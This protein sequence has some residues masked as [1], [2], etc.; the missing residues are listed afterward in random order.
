MQ[1]VPG[2]EMTFEM[3]MAAA[4]GLIG[5]LFLLWIAALFRIRRLKKRLDR[6]FKHSEVKDL[7]SLIERIQN[8]GFELAAQ[9]E[10][11]KQ[12]HAA[13][14]EK[15]DRSPAFIGFKRYNAFGDGGSQLSFSLAFVNE[16]LDG[17]V[18]SALHTRDECRV[19]AKQLQAGTSEV[20]LS[21]EEKDVIAQ[22][23]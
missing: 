15:M 5:I 16:S 1:E 18:L 7:P 17:V 10:T 14:R 13:V 23:K 21:P 4:Y 8:Q 19:Y 11:L 20:P 9:V 6:F 22:A 12:D 3:M 2:A